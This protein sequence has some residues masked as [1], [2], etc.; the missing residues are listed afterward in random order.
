MRSLQ[1]R[2]HEAFAAAVEQARRSA[3]RKILGLKPAA[4]DAEIE[5]TDGRNRSLHIAEVWLDGDR[6]VGG[7]HSEGRSL[8][9]PEVKK[10]WIRRQD[11]GRVGAVFTVATLAIAVFIAI[12]AFPSADDF[13]TAAFWGAAVTLV[14]DRFKALSR[15]TVL[16][17][18]DA[19]VP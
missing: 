3:L 4:L 10:V 1:Q 15:L 18:R 2:S 9:L 14:L 13:L 8:P 17:D 7:G 5:M 16:Y 12:P 6:V 11:W 19:P